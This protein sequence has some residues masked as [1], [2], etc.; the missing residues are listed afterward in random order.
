MKRFMFDHTKLAELREG[1]G[2]SVYKSAKEL[3]RNGLDVSH[4]TI[5]NW[6]DGKSTPNCKQLAEIALFYGK[7]AGYFFVKLT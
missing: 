1:A 2:L 6:E 3:S 5:M 4:Q 7:P